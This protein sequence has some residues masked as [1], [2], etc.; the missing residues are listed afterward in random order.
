MFATITNHIRPTTICIYLSCKVFDKLHSRSVVIEELSNGIR[1]REAVI[2][3]NKTRTLL[4]NGIV[5]F[6]SATARQ[7][8]GKYDVDVEGD[9]FYLT[10]QK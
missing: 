3:D 6:T 8:V 2:M 4:K 5:A 1:F 7:L 10:K 9:W